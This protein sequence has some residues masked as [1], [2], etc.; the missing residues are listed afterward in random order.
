MDE[1]SEEEILS[2]N[3]GKDAYFEHSTQALLWE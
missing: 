3:I 1:A 2:K